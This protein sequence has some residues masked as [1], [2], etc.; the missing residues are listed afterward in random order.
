MSVAMDFA[1]LKS[2][3][4]AEA[5]AYM[6]GR[7]LVGET[8]SAYDLWHEEHGRAFTVSRLARAD[9]LEALQQGL[10]RSVA[11]DLSRRDWIRSTEKLLQDAGWW[12]TKEVTDPRTGE[13]LTTR[14]D[15]ARL[16]LIFDTNVRQAQAGGQWQRMLRNRRTHPFARYVSMDDGRVRPL[17]RAWHGV[18]LPLD[19]A[20][21]ATHHPPNG[22]RCRCRVV[23]VTQQ[24]YEQGQFEERGN[25]QDGDDGP[26]QQRPMR[27]QVPQDGDTEWRNP[28]TGKLQ[29]IPQGIDPGFDYNAGTQGARA[30]FEAMVQAKLARLSPQVAKAAVAQR[31]S[32]GLPTE[33]FMGQRP[34]LADLPPVPVVELTGEE[35]GAG[36]SHTQLMAQATKLLRQLQVSDGLVND[37]TGWLLAI[38]RKGVKKMGDNQQQNRPS[39]QAVAM[40]RALVQRAVVVERHKDKEHENEFVNSIFRLFAPMQI[41]G[42]LYR[43]KLTVKEF[44]Q[45][46]NI[47]KLLHALE[48]T[49]IENALPLGT[50][51]NSPETGVGT[52][53]P[54]TV[55]RTVSLPQLLQNATRN[56]G[57]PYDL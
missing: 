25:L 2:L 40:L 48:A 22:W 12:G 18:T 4:P 42:Q 27:K 33:D 55:R 35:F 41:A 17:H 30:A 45:G 56:D 31:L 15:H 51:P 13:L 52:A 34:G 8:F 23:G 29:R 50:L 46:N 9:L 3:Q 16:Q 1:R 43:V 19:D 14:F 5:V 26:L 53:Q 6:A 7:E 24:E 32:M 44:Q 11:G 28:A 20:W 37:D 49:Q 54:T 21:W 38:N 57:K 39:L 10:A 47:R 36:L